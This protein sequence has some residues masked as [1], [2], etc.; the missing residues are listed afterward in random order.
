M[1]VRAKAPL[2][3]SFAG[4]GTDV[5]P[6]P[7]LYGGCVLNATINKCAYTVLEIVDKSGIEVQSLDYDQMAHFGAEESLNFNG[8]MDLAKAV[9]KRLDCG[10]N[11][12][13]IFTHNDAPPGS[14]LGSS[15]ARS[16]QT[17][18]RTIPQ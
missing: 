13:K 18:A 2:R 4:G 12:F 5:S 15:S 9:I 7:E 11:G 16:I 14:G 3:I 6:Y 8:N 1:I 17:L 10:R